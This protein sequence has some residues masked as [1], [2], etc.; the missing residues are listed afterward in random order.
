MLDK[1]FGDGVF[2]RMEIELN[3]LEIR[4]LMQMYRV[5]NLVKQKIMFC[6]V[7]KI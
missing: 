5:G 7:R 3:G 6:L 2:W 1:G 4:S